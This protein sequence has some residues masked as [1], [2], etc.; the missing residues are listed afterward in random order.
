MDVMDLNTTIEI[1]SY[2]EEKVAEDVYLDI[3]D[4][5]I[6]I[7]D[8]SATQP[9]KLNHILVTG[10]SGSGKSTLANQLAEETGYPIIHM[11]DEPDI[12]SWWSGNK[13]NEYLSPSSSDF[14]KFEKI[15]RR[16]VI[17]AV[18]RLTTPSIIEGTQV[19]AAPEVW[20]KYR[21][22]FVDTPQRTVV[23]QRLARDR[24][25]G[26]Y[27][28]MLPGSRVARLRAGIAKRIM[29]TLDP[30]MEAYRSYPGTELMRPSF[31]EKGAFVKLAADAKKFTVAVDL[32]GTLAET[33]E[34]H[35][36]KK[37]GLPIKR[38]IELVQKLKDK[39]ATIIIWTVRGDKKL[40]AAF[41]D[42]NNVPYD[43]I[44]Y[45]PDQPENS[46]GKIIA[47]AYIDDRAIHIDDLDQFVRAIEKR[48]KKA[49]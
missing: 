5:L 31:A 41:G 2:I 17:N 33:I 46:S 8:A 23:R 10:H 16:V 48:L 21:R 35:N 18:N 43:Y 39:G 36:P 9:K 45:N 19:A 42:E 30:E 6:K 40:I 15:K 29:H 12:K 49:A 26:D 28:V 24:E 11:D 4:E 47:D 37:I 25:R 38:N 20:S 1:E 27:G 3:Y 13:D 7:A 14:D 34:P 32:D 44:N 22:I